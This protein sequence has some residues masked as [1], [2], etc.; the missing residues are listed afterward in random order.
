MKRGIFKYQ[1][2]YIHKH[3]LESYL[4]PR[5]TGIIQPKDKTETY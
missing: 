4:T 5:K 1:V 2:S 3:E